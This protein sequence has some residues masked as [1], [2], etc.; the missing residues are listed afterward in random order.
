MIPTN[1]THIAFDADDTLW[2]HE[3]VYVDAKHRCA[4]LLEAYLAEGED[5]EQRLYE[6]EKKNLALFGYG[7][8][9][10]MLS[11]METAIELSGGAISGRELQEIIKMGKE[12]L[13]HPI[14]LLPYVAEAI[15]RLGA[16]YELLL[17][18]K[19]DL[20]NQESKIARSGLA[21]HF[22]A[23]EIV[24]EKSPATYRDICR[25][26]GIQ[27]ENLLM[28]GNSLRSDVLP[29]LAIGGHAAYLPHTYTWMHERAVTNERPV[30]RDYLK[31]SSLKEL[32]DALLP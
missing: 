5:L 13:A 29:V 12:M 27:P 7:I 11:M 1:L 14:E 3:H 18:T 19:G 24:S 10:W 25:R 17:I 23:I 28:I 32:V 31:P 16:R 15:D 4:K 8:K 26:Q 2:G 20:F 22:S 21:A 9:G 30:G 6:F